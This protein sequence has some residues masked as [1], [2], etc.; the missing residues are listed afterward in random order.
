MFSCN[1]NKRNLTTMSIVQSKS[2]SHE[3]SNPLSIE[4]E[5]KGEEE[6]EFNDARLLFSD[7]SEIELCVFVVDP[8][9]SENTPTPPTQT[10]KT[11]ATTN[12]MV[13]PKLNLL[14]T[15]NKQVSSSTMFLFF[16]IHLVLDLI[17][18][19]CLLDLLTFCTFLNTTSKD[20]NPSM[21]FNNLKSIPIHNF[22][23][24]ILKW[25]W[26]VILLPSK[27]AS[28]PHPKPK[29]HLMLACILGISSIRVPLVLPYFCLLD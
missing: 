23:F 22:S 21:F 1:V 10:K 17:A 20:M 8:S 16:H 26:V 7:G 24:W 18:L 12:K 25:L 15:I 27:I 19:F 29:L 14:A 4:E 28:L 13:T 3:H 5:E 6:S 2:N 11:K 9:S